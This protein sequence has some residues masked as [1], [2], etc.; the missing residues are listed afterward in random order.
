MPGSIVSVASTQPDLAPSMP[1]SLPTKVGCCRIHTL[2]LVQVVFSRM[3]SVT[4]SKVGA[5]SGIC[6]VTA[7]DGVSPT[8]LIA[9]T[10]P[11]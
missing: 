7:A 1:Q 4:T 2:S 8:L 6:A 9:K 10:W 5:S 11:V 3:S